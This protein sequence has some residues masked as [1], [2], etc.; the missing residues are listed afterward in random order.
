[1]GKWYESGSGFVQPP[2]TEVC[3]WIGRSSLET[4]LVSSEQAEKISMGGER[5]FAALNFSVG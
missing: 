4:F 2:P 3:V 5:P 1:M